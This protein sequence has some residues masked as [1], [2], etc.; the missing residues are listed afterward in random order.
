MARNFRRQRQSAPISELNVTNLIDLGF[1]LLIVFMIATP[2]INQEQTIP[3]DL[4]VESQSEQT[5]P[6]P[7]TQFESITIRADGTVSLSGEVVRLDA[8]AD[9][10][11]PFAGQSEPPVFRIRMDADSTAQQF[12]TVMDA[13]KTQRLSRI[14]FDTQV[15]A[16]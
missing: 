11:A 4:P 7:D 14:T 13:L 12:I 10:L 9:A 15:S 1:T 8:L 2:L 6:D 16:Q 3:V 5:P